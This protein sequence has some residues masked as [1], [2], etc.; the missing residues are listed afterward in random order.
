MSVSTDA[1]LEL[2]EAAKNVQAA[3]VCVNRVVIDRIWGH[4]EYTADTQVMIRKAHALLLEARDA[5]A[6]V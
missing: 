2:K 1:D 3:L 5:L 6:F 4:S